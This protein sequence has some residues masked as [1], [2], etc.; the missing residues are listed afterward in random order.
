MPATGPTLTAVPWRFI[1]TGGQSVITTI[2]DR[3]AM[4]RTIA[5]VLNGPSVWT[6]D[7]PSDNPEVNIVY[8]GDGFGDPFVSYGDRLVYGFR[9]EGFPS[10][11][12]CRYAGMLNINDDDAT[13]DQPYT[14]LTAQ[15]PWTYMY[16]KPIITDSGLIP[17]AGEGWVI[18]GATCTADQIIVDLLL[19]CETVTGGTGSTRIDY[20]QSG[21]YTGTLET[22]AN[23]VAF[24][25]TQ[26]DTVGSALDKL[27]ATGS[28]DFVLEPIYDPINR[29]GYTSQLSVFQR[30]GQQRPAMI[31]A[32]DM[33]SRSLVGI[34]RLLDGT[35]IANRVQPFQSD[36]TPLDLQSPPVVDTAAQYGQWFSQ[37]TL[38][39]GT[40]RPYG[41]LLGEA[42]ALLQ[43][44]GKRTVQINPAPER[45]PVPYLEFNNGDFIPVYASNR[46]RQ[47]LAPNGPASGDGKLAD[48]R[49]YG[50]EVDISDDD[51]ET[52]T[53][54][55]ISVDGTPP[56]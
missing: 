27:A 5:S 28:C 44:A 25:L 35:Q 29:P 34:S 41:D 9:Q 26:S 24:S 49:I 20:G 38:P 48:Q 46:L 55:L 31:F 10:L 53:N 52:V 12:V 39:Q 17:S 56:S 13:T 16:S 18:T 32:W 1:V 42:Q 23:L 54:M 2:L 43:Q 7:V 21:F 37:L 36:G 6:A 22:C 19:N 4:N 47:A 45:A 11:Y 33:P 40:N 51:V 3:V 14:H 8:S 15:D 50:F 30:A